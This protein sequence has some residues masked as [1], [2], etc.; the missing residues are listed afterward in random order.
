MANDWITTT[1]AAKTSGYTADHLRA[2]I[3][4]GRITGRKFGIVWQVSR[5]S[6]ANFVRLQEVKGEKRG[7]KPSALRPRNKRAAAK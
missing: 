1:D 5:K 7:R 3:R 2:M 6:L 4:D